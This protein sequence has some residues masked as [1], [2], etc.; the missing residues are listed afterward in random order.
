[1][2]PV[3]FSSST[4]APIASNPYAHFCLCF[5]LSAIYLIQINKQIDADNVVNF[6]WAN[7]DTV[8]FT[9]ANAQL[10]PHQVWLHHINGNDRDRLLFQDDNEEF[11]VDVNITKDKVRSKYF[12]RF[13]FNQIALCD[14]ELQFAIVL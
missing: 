3:V 12:N 14:G 10:R 7:A 9:R 11:F 4:C 2:K 6:V 5:D 13:K 8:V 1:M